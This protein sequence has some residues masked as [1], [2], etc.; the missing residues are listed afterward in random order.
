MDGYAL[1]ME[2]ARPGELPVKGQ[3]QPGEPACD[4]PVGAAVRIFTGGMVPEQAQLVIQREHVHE[5]EQSIT[6]PPG[7]SLKQGQHIRFTGENGQPGHV[8]CQPG[9]PLTAPML[10]AIASAGLTH[11]KTFRPLRVAILV[12]GGEVLDIHQ[13][14][15]PWQ[16][17]DS[18]G[19]ALSAL[20]HQPWLAS[21]SPQHVRDDPD[22]LA[23]TIENLLTTA[24]ALLLTGGVSAGDYDFVPSVLGRIGAQIIFHKLPIRPG[25]PVLGAVTNTG[26]PILG[27]PGNPVSVM[28]TARRIALPALRKRAGFREVHDPAILVNATGQQMAPPGLTWFALV[29]LAADGTAVLVESKGSGD[30]V[31][32]A[33][34]QGFVEVPAG[35]AIAGLRRYFPWA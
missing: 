22:A 4:L 15:Q 11:I 8:I 12:T 19:P 13:Q 35:Q 33:S 25:K 18:N 17:R 10:A 32:A 30:W 21:L 31:N 1:R 20:L 14:P 7:L 27:L 2:D 16:I 28:A 23:A 29:H 26:C 5:H 9:Q 24:D 34:S 3:V 6:L